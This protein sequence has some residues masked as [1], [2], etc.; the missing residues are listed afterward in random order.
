[1]TN[2]HARG[3]PDSTGQCRSA[4]VRL[5]PLRLIC[6]GKLRSASAT[7]NRPRARAL[8]ASA[9]AATCPWLGGCIAREAFSDVRWGGAAVKSASSASVC[10]APRA[11][12]GRARRCTARRR[13]R[14]RRAGPTS[15]TRPRPSSGSRRS[16]RSPPHAR[17]PQP[18][19]RPRRRARRRTGASPRS[20]RSGSSSLQPRRRRPRRYPPH[21]SAPC[22]PRRSAGKANRRRGVRGP[23]GALFVRAPPRLTPPR[24]HEG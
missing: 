10:A 11:G 3:E 1:M 16:R 24:S 20:P 23:L 4:R 15:R 2:I 5:V 13:G 19:R 12:G 6:S 8:T 7:A 18:R 22:S 14:S 9:R 21:L 17:P